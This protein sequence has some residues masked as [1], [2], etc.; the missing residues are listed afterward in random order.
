MRKTRAHDFNSSYRKDKW[1]LLMNLRENRATLQDRRYSNSTSSVIYSLS[2]PSARSTKVYAGLEDMVVQMD[3][4]NAYDRN[5]DPI[6]SYGVRKDYGGTFNPAKTYDPGRN[7]WNFLM[8]DLHGYRVNSL[9]KQ[10][11]LLTV[12]E[13]RLKP[14]DERWHP[15]IFQRSERRS[16]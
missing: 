16:L 11:P 12:S 10:G 1:D 15:L 13:N 14:I 5:P 7:L 9:L 8:H 6:F 2:S 3:F 4:I